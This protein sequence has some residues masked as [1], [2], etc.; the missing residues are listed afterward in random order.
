MAVKR[1]TEKELEEKNL[2]YLYREVELPLVKLLAKMEIAGVKVDK[3]RLTELSQE[4]AQRMS[5]LEEKI[6]GLAG[7]SS[8]STRQSNWAR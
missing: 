6:F 3:K 8:T 5:V 7:R 4:F 1:N 2:M